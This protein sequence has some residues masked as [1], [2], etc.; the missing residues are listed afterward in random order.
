MSAGFLHILA[1]ICISPEFLQIFE[2]MR[3]FEK[4]L[5]Y[6]ETQRNSHRD[7]KWIEKMFETGEKPHLCRNDETFSVAIFPD[8]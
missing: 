3:S 7:G 1:D 8:L 4:K 6:S 2:G 5:T